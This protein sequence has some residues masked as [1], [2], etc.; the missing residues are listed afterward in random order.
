[1]DETVSGKIN[2]ETIIVGG[3]S[4]IVALLYLMPASQISLPVPVMTRQW[5]YRHHTARG[6]QYYC[7]E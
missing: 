1:M 5:I 7:L 6:Q 2:S 3:Y 4:G